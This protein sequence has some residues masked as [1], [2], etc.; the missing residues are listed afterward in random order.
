[1]G[2]RR[3]ARTLYR[4]SLDR[5]VIDI[6]ALKNTNGHP[7]VTTRVKMPVV[8]VAISSYQLSPTL[9]TIELAQKKNAAGLNRASKTH[10]QAA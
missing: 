8:M 1:M 7:Y 10:V 9:P 5:N 6:F 3:A 4:A 2:L